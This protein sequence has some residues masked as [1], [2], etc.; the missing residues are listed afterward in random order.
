[1]TNRTVTNASQQKL[2]SDLGDRRF[3]PWEDTGCSRGFLCDQRR[4]GN[5][6][7]VRLGSRTGVLLR[8]WLK[9]LDNLPTIAAE[10]SQK[11][12]KAARERWRRARESRQ[13]FGV[14][15]S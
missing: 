8:D 10:P 14:P 13:S 2:A 1:L 3:I 9:F 11:H 15:R 5:L 4:K 7:L 6:R 12:Q